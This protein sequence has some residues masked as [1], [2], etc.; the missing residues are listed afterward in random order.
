MLR[1]AL[2]LALALLP[3]L[4][5]AQAVAMKTMPPVAED[6]DAFP[7]IDHPK[8]DAERDINRAV[9]ELDR[10]AAANSKNCVLDNGKPG[11]W[12]RKVQVT[13]AGPGWLSYRIAEGEYCGG[14]HPDSGTSS[15]VY[16]LATGKLVDWTKLLPGPVAG[17]N[18][19]NSKQLYE[20]YLAGYK[21]DAPDCLHSVKDWGADGP[22]VMIAWLDASGDGVAV[23]FDMNHAN[24]GC[25]EP[26]TISTATLR[27]MGADKRLMD[28]IDAAHAKVPG[29]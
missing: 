5:M 3:G 29:P 18:L 22:P 4:A 1:V 23:Q 27:K 6:L 13:M 9:A 24:Q 8:N 11:D 19:L 10:E 7:Q 26:V 2:A 16:D 12:E 25:A 28:A 17:S 15:L 21:S 14:A 20:L